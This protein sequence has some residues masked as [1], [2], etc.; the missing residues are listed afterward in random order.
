[1]RYKKFLELKLFTGAHFS[2]SFQNISQD[3]LG[4]CEQILWKKAMKNRGG[5]S[6]FDIFIHSCPNLLSKER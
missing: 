5:S 6:V 3:A 4:F 2:S 1:M